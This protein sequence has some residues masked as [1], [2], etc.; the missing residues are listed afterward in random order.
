MF[1]RH[2]PAAALPSAPVV[3]VLV[4]V[5]A[6]VLEPGRMQSGGWSMLES[7]CPHPPLQALPQNPRRVT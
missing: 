1:M 3:R 2:P 5:L 7:R 6:P 4:L